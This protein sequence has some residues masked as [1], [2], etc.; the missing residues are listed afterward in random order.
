MRAILSIES[1]SP[2]LTGIGRYTWELASRL[3]AYLGHGSV[4]YYRNRSWIKQPDTLLQIEKPT[5]S[6]MS[7]FIP[8]SARSALLKWNCKGAVFHGP[9]YFLPPCA[10]IGVATIHDLSVF[11][12]PETHPAERINQF[13]REF[14]RSI[15]KAVHLITDS[16]ATR[17]EV[18]DFLGWPE[19]KI[20]AV[21]L[22]VSERFRPHTAAELAVV[23][24]KYGLCP[25]QYC[26]CVSTL[27]PRKKIDRLLCAYQGLPASIRQR[28]PL[29]LVGGSGWLSE[30]LHEQITTL[31]GQGWLHYLG[32]VEEADLPMLYAG[33]RSFVYPSIYEGFGLP[34]LEAMASGVPV[35]TSNQTSLPEVTRG[36]ALLVNPDDIDAL[37]Q[38][39][40]VSLLDDAWH[41]AARE[42]S[43]RVAQG[44][45]WNQCIEQTISVY[46]HILKE[47]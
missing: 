20:S 21:P 46:N 15:N 14:A 41:L 30:S 12:F 32:F 29:V 26:L 39:I 5:L 23:L 43:I 28:F 45:T 18:I 6:P 7:K 40:H 16:N 13:E 38:S 9:N 17:Q 27:E 1:L 3:P 24:K 25:H 8:R 19:N 2:R 42:N 44:Y 34:V 11:K 36:A 37:S 31:A 33:A 4:R 35:V 10:D 22:G 47:Q